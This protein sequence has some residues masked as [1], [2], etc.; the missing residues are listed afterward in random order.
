MCS[1]PPPSANNLTDGMCMRR[2]T[3]NLNGKDPEQ[4]DLDAGP[5]AV[6]KGSRDTV[7]P[8]YGCMIVC[9]CVCVCVLGKRD[10]AEVDM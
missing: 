6:P 10:G 9:V 3:L 1:I 7:E 2:F 8:I 5:A 4:Q